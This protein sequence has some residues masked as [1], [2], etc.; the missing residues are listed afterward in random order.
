MTRFSVVPGNHAPSSVAAMDQNTSI[1]NGVASDD[2]HGS[3]T[4]GVE[5]SVAEEPKPK[6]PPNI[7]HGKRILT[8]MQPELTVCR[9]TSRLIHLQDNTDVSVQIKTPNAQFFGSMPRSDEDAPQSV[10]HAPAGF[11]DFIG[12][13]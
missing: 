12:V 2:D 5:E 6:T 10:I 1:D 4:I 11:G 7:N 8:S 9:T 3:N 13:C